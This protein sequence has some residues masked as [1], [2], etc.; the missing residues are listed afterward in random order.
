MTQ[1]YIVNPIH[2]FANT[3]TVTAKNAE[4]AIKQVENMINNTE[5]FSEDLD[6]IFYVK[7]LPTGEWVVNRRKD[8]VKAFVES[9]KN[10]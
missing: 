8:M 3:I 1:E 7:S 9:K 5:E 6:K 10:E 4:D 2:Q